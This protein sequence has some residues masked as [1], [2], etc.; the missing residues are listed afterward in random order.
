MGTGGG[1]FVAGA[2]EEER[3]K[4]GSRVVGAGVIGLERRNTAG[5]VFVA[6]GI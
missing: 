5:G 6:G 4:T 2:V 3:G 1:I